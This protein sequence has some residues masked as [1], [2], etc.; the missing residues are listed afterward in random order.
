M[1]VSVCV[2]GT[3]FRCRHRHTSAPAH[4]HAH[5]SI[6]IQSHYSI[7]QHRLHS[8]APAA[9]I[10]FSHFGVLFRARFVVAVIVVELTRSGRARKKNADS[11]SQRRGEKFSAQL[12][13]TALQ[14]G[15]W[16]GIVVW[17]AA[18]IVL[19]GVRQRDGALEFRFGHAVTRAAGICLYFCVKYLL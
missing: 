19:V 12:L 2:C 15:I 10:E 17:S 3:F 9:E 5:A 14:H 1:R 7:H 8:P 11:V 18:K 6:R 13:S 16:D 4:A